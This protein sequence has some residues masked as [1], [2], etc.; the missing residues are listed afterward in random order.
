M[1]I[2]WVCW[3][4]YHATGVSAWLQEVASSGSISPLLWVSA[5]V[6]HIDSWKSLAHPWH[7]SNPLP[8]TAADFYLF[9]WLTGSLPWFSPH[10][11]L[12][13]TSFSSPS[14]LPPISLPP[15]A[16]YD[17]FLLPLLSLIQASLLVSSFLFSCF[18][19]VE[20]SVSNLHFMA[21]ILL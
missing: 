3:C 4:S 12:N 7:T 10:L 11:I 1:N 20:C 5:K 13:S 18:G 15:S 17:N 8:P 9:S 19:S 21:N 14:S 16:S 2:S 6:T